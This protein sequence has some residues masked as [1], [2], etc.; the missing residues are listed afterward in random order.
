MM[1]K[2]LLCCLCIAAFLIL[3][4]VIN[5]IHFRF[6]PVSVVLYDSIIDVAIVWA[7]SLPFLV[8]G[9]RT[10]LTGL[11]IG[12]SYVLAILLCA[13]YALAV[14][15]IIDRSLSVYILEKLEQR[16]GRIAAE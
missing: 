2:A 8:W 11:E 1:R 10:R 6:F 14:P 9:R 7:I 13:M 15:T 4:L 12:L 5:I 3:F 16:G